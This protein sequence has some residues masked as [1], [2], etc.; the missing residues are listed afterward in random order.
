MSCVFCG[1][2][3]E[4]QNVTF[5]YGEDGDYLFIEDVPAEVCLQCGE[6]T[7]SPEVTDD[8]IRIAKR[9]LKPNKVIEVP[10]F[11]YAHRA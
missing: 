11:R 6:K 9:R 1:G 10:V 5:I 3:V 8:L 2:K 4:T 7:Y